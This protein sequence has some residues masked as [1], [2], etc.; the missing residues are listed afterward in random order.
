MAIQD[1]TE[2]IRLKP[3]DA[4]YY[5]NRGD[6]RLLKGEYKDAINDFNE[7]IRLD[8]NNSGSFSSRGFAWSEKRSR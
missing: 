1:Y 5:S 2:A 8:P 3:N 6:V 4:Y 7:A